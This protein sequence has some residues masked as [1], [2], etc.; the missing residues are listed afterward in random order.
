[1]AIAA[2]CGEWPLT[3][4]LA[5]RRDRDKI[6]IY[7]HRSAQRTDTPFHVPAAATRRR[8]RLSAQMGR[9]NV[10][11]FTNKSSAT[12]ISLKDYTMCL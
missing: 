2:A 9:P 6:R 10:S 1:M 5:R 8:S 7:I 12:E 11:F 4:S 3:R